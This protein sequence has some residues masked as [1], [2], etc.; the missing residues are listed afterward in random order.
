MFKTFPKLFG[1]LSSFLLF[2]AGCDLTTSTNTTT[3]A[4]TT[5]VTFRDWPA[6]NWVATPTL[7]GRLNHEL[8]VL[9]SGLNQSYPVYRY[10]PRSY[11]T[12]SGPFP[13]IYTLD[14]DEDSYV[15]SLAKIL[16]DQNIE[17]IL[18][19]IGTSG[20]RH[21][22]DLMP[23]SVA[24]HQFV[25]ET[26]VQAAEEG[27]VVDTSQRTISG[28][29][30][31]GL[32]TYGA[33]LRDRP[34]TRVFR[35]FISLD[36]SFWVQADDNANITREQQLFQATQGNLPE[37]TLVLASSLYG[38]DPD[39]STLYSRLLGRNFTGLVIHRIPA[40]AMG[41]GEMF[42]PGFGDAVRLLF[43]A[44]ALSN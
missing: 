36:G 17:A 31:G 32:F 8:T 41:H 20:R 26:V 9:R 3:I 40:Y 22:D 42:Y 37:T 10:L 6:W 4:A 13:I 44:P 28:H 39:V 7:A 29:S 24:F 25:T 19:G 21:I 43:P 2:C 38:N 23:G 16:E 27:L 34:S 33:M 14:S 35:N 30:Y 12:K 1:A 11:T 15:I 18:V 5:T